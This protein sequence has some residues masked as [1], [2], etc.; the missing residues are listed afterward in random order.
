MNS[1]LRSHLVRCYIL[2]HLTNENPHI[3]RVREAVKKIFFNWPC[4]NLPLPSSLMVFETL[5]EGEETFNFFP[6]MARPLSPLLLNGTAN[7]KNKRKNKRKT[8]L[9]K[10]N[11]GQCKEVYQTDYIPG[12]F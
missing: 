10:R 9:L 1:V 12:G 2:Y 11:N 8:R 7:K 5:A 6:L 4:L 3:D